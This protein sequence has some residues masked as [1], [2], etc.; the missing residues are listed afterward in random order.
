MLLHK[1]AEDYQTKE[2]LPLLHL[3]LINNYLKNG[4]KKKS[5]YSS[6]Q[7]ITC[8]FNISERLEKSS[9]RLYRTASLK[10]HGDGVTNKGTIQKTYLHSTDWQ[11]K[12]KSDLFF[13]LIIQKYCK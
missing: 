10:G 7:E 11:M 1:W 4:K 3:V 5:Y 13:N 9:I 12:I 2:F 8:R 6:Q